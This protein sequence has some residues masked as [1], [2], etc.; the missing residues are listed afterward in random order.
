MLKWALQRNLATA[1]GRGQSPGGQWL[2]PPRP[3]RGA[4]RT[5][6]SAAGAELPGVSAGRPS[7][8]LL[9]VGKR[10]GCGQP[11]GPVAGGRP[12][13]GTAT[14]TEVLAGAATA[15]ATSQSSLPP[16]VRDHPGVCFVSVCGLGVDLPA[17]CPL[18]R[19]RPRPVRTPAARPWSLGTFTLHPSSRGCVAGAFK[20]TTPGLGRVCRASRSGNAHS[21]WPHSFLWSVISSFWQ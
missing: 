13:A 19:R 15:T 1:D 11:L 16:Q 4:S 5:R 8:R 12:L 2:P 17:A 14:Q 6:A 20:E 10:P 21:C 7:C 3:A 9:V 18:T